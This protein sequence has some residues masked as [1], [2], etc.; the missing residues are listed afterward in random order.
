MTS[1]PFHIIQKSLLDIT[2]PDIGAALNWQTKSS[3][4][5][6]DVICTQIE[7]CFSEYEQSDHHLI[8]EK[9]VVDLG[10]LPMGSLEKELPERFYSM[11]SEMLRERWSISS[12]AGSFRAT[13]EDA[14]NPCEN[15]QVKP[16][17]KFHQGS[18]DSN[19]RKFCIWFISRIE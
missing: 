1:R 16:L 18:K 11:F 19:H 4:S 12:N 9:V 10:A 13:E 3:R 8:I 14:L 7:R 6:V 5:F 2:V 15:L 17:N